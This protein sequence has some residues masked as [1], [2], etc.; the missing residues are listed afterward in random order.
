MQWRSRSYNERG[1][2]LKCGLQANFMPGFIEYN[3]ILFLAGH[4][5]SEATN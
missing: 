4:L 1:H 5:M 2:Y 3:Q